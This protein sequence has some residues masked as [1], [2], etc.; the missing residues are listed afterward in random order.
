MAATL[1][2]KIKQLRD[3]KGY[4]LD[5]L[6]KLTDSSKSYIWELENRNPPRPS[7]EKLAR[8]ADALEVTMEY[9]LG[10]EVTLE[11][12]TDRKFYRKYRGMS[13]GTKEKIRQ[14]IEIW[15]DD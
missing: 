5:E 13:P 11:D 1:G 12:A 7:A 8:I 3:E 9:F 2:E 6:A 10:D 14:M 4:T 15:D